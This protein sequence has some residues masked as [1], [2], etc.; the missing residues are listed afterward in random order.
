M[1]VVYLACLRREKIEVK[2]IKSSN[3]PG[4]PAIPLI[5]DVLV[6]LI[7]IPSSRRIADKK[8]ECTRHGPQLVTVQNAAIGRQVCDL[9]DVGVHIGRIVEAA[10]DEAG[11]T[12]SDDIWDGKWVRVTQGLQFRSVFW[13]LLYMPWPELQKRRDWDLPRTQGDRHSGGLHAHRLY[14]TNISG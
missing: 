5:I 12:A 14:Y 10:L 1:L 8:V 4:R 7:Y 13:V 9:L 2:R 6:K 11:V 3:S